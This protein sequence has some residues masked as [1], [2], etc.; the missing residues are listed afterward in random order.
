[1]GLHWFGKKTFMWAAQVRKFVFQFRISVLALALLLSAQCLRAQSSCCSSPDSAPADQNEDATSESHNVPMI[2]S[3]V[4]GPYVRAG[5]VLTGGAYRPLALQAEAGLDLE[6]RFCVANASAAYDNDR[7]TKDRDQPNRKGHDR[8]LD[9]GIYCRILGRLLPNRFFIG[10]GYR[11]SQ[12]STTNY[13]KTANRP[14]I[15]GAYDF[16]H[17]SCAQC[18][19]DFSMRIEM[20]WV[21]TGNDW[22]NGTHG[23]EIALTFPSPREKHHWFW[24][25]RTGIYRSHA[26]VTE[27]SNLPLTQLQRATRSFWCTADF[28]IEYRF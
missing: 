1:M 11:W 4:T 17:R 26:T 28:G 20:N 25:Q 24:E 5:P 2:M 21:I 8:F 27:P 19:R 12:L 16:V 14:Q 3:S 9:G 13:T 22:Q 6:T 10:G 18:E 23:P 7:M 15:G